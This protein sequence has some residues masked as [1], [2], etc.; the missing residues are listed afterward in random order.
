MRSLL[1]EYLAGIQ[2]HNASPNSGEITINFV[3]FDR[4]MI[5][6]NRFQNCAKHRDIPLTFVNLIN[7]MSTDISVNE[8]EDLKEGPARGNDAQVFIE[9][10]KGIAN[11]GNNGLG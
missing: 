9:H 4:R 11:G 7:Q 10:K 2:E 1:I 3:S 8:A 6:G 5:L